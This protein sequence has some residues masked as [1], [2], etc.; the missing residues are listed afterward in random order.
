[1]RSIV[2]NVNDVPGEIGILIWHIRPSEIST[3]LW[4]YIMQALQCQFHK[5]FAGLVLSQYGKP[6]MTLALL[7]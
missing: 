4:I 5:S 6:H 2:S 7:A 1:M 3:K